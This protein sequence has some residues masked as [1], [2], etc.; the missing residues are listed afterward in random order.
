MKNKK[1]IITIY[2]NP[3]NSTYA[4]SWSQIDMK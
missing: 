2:T 4:N 1:N 3:E